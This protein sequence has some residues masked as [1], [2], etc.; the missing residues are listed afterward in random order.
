MAIFWTT[1]PAPR[2]TAQDEPPPTYLPLSF[3]R[4]SKDTVNSLAPHGH[5]RLVGPHV[6]VSHLAEVNMP[7]ILSKDLIT[8]HEENSATT[9]MFANKLSV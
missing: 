1:R 2:P 6:I 3:A 7:V 4:V 9:L 5:E 8:P